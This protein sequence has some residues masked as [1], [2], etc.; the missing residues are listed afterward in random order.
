[1]WQP[2]VWR[3]GPAGAMFV[4]ASFFGLGG[5]SAFVSSPSVAAPR[6][7]QKASSSARPW[8]AAQGTQSAP[9]TA[10]A[11]NGRGSGVSLVGFGLLWAA[12][13]R[14]GSAR[15]GAGRIVV[16]GRNYECNIRGKKG[17]REAELAKIIKKCL[18]AV[19]M[20]IK[21]GGADETN[22]KALIRA[23]KD[24]VK[25]GVSRSTI[26]GR[27]K[28]F[29]EG[30]EQ[31]DQIMFE[32]TGPGGAA[33]MARTLTDSKIRTRAH[34][35]EAFKKSDGEIGNTGCA[36]FAFET[37]G[38]LLFEG[39]NEDAIMEAAMEADAELEELETQEDG[40]VVALTAPENFRAVQEALEAKD[41]VSTSADVEYLSITEVELDE[42]DTYNLKFLIHQLEAID[43]VQEVV[44]NAKLNDIELEL[45]SYGIPMTWMTVQKL[46]K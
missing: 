46:K 22:N 25:D 19:I 44:H 28:K 14:R 43:D 13:W 27:I 11:A 35:Q 36:N 9:E 20:A 18:S 6:A 41:L 31:V 42:K 26:D 21:E 2:C 12:G 8:A 45:N 16:R 7:V 37:K 30:K 23:I 17:K 5:A 1:M 33:V 40:S 34:I 3:Q 38:V 29:V 10:A 24:G 4:L 32:G 15:I 39:T